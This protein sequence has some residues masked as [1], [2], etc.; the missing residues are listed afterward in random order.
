MSL[1]DTHT[2]DAALQA[3]PVCTV[4]STPPAPR[5]LYIPRRNS[6]LNYCWIAV[7]IVNSIYFVSCSVFLEL[8]NKRTLRIVY[9]STQAAEEAVA[10]FAAALTV[11]VSKQTADEK[12]CKPVD[13]SIE[14][15]RS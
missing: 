6:V 7:G 8:S 1:P 2:S 4:T 15:F 14:V 10:Q 13:G 12:W 11:F 3:R 9:S 5:L